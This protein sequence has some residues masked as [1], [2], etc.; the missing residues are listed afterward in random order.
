M[1]RKRR[2]S[3]PA[4]PAA[5][6]PPPAARRT[7]RLALR[8]L[9]IVATAAA[10]LLSFPPM[11]QWYLAYVA[12]AGWALVASTRATWGRA[13]VVSAAVS[14]LFWG[15]ALYWLWWITLVGYVAL[16]LFLS[17]WWALAGVLLRAA[18]RRGWP[19]WLVLPVLWTALEY[20]RAHALSG[21]PWFFLAQTQYR[22]LWLIQITDVTGQYGVS[23]FVAM[24]NGLLVEA[25]L[26]WKQL[27]AA[28]GLRRLRPLAAPSIACL[29][30]L[31]GLMGYGIWRTG[32]QTQTPGP[33]V[34][35]AQEAFPVALGRSGPSDA[36]TFRAH[37]DTSRRLHQWARRRGGRIDLMIWPETMLRQGL[38]AGFAN[39]DPQAL[40]EETMRA[41]LAR[42]FRP[43]L[44]EQ[45]GV[46]KLFAAV[47]KDNR[48]WNQV[49]GQLVGELD[50][51]LLAGGITYH[52]DPDPV[53]PG[54]PWLARNSALLFVP[55]GTRVPEYA[56]MQLVPFSEYVPLRRQWLWAHR[57]MR[58]FVPDV[59]EQLD[60]PYD[61]F[62]FEVPVGEDTLRLGAPICYEGTFARV[63]R[64]LVMGDSNKRAQLLANISNDG[65]FVWPGT[66]RGTTEQAQ[67]LAHY[68]FRA[69]ETRTPVVRAVNTGISASIDP[70]GRIV[71]V[72]EGVRDGRPQR[73]MIRGGLLL[74]GGA[75]DREQTPRLELEGASLDP[76]W[77]VS[78]PRI[79][80]DSRTTLFSLVGDLFAQLVSAAAVLLIIGLWWGRKRRSNKPEGSLHVDESR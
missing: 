19:L 64:S 29:V 42:R 70:N 8:L 13:A 66:S 61:P 12:L 69:I 43:E 39:L 62:V 18:Q 57:A 4:S 56:K 79:L 44:V 27:R 76:A 14:L 11:D 34:A 2:R 17:L 10:L 55:G 30:I 47:L 24:V 58:S 49:I 38:N 36:D 41:F 74:D 75:P 68:V 31:A 16:V 50:A 9:T 15:A 53:E 20:L 63:C 21:F 32:Q 6:G 54:N 59:M 45:Q 28:T 52:I 51:P 71:A 35:V 65:W 73:V 37:S 25:V 3:T 5:E 48:D 60:T 33:V 22:R 77:L 7:R 72:V 80:L 1:A 40:D 23:F 67:H 78:G 26:R 46:R